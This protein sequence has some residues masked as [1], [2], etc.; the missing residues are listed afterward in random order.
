MREGIATLSYAVRIRVV[1]KYLGH[2]GIMMAI[3]TLAP[4]I[5]SLIFGEYVLSVRYALVVIALIALAAPSLRLRV[6]VGLQANEALAVTALVFVLTPLVMTYP[7]KGADL[8]VVDALFEAISAITTTGLS[9]LPSV[10]ALPKTSLFARAWMQWYGGLGIVVL[11]VALLMGHHTAARRLTEPVVGENMLTTARTYARRML[12]VYAALTVAGLIVLWLVIG[13]GFIALLHLLTAVS[14]GGFSPFD[15]SLAGLAQWPARFVLIA[16]A[17]CGAVPMVLYYRAYH[18]GWRNL[19]QDTELRAL[20]F[21]GLLTCTLLGFFMQNSL[22]LPLDEITAH[23]ILLGLS[24]QTG[25]GFSSLNV[26]ELDNA[27][28]LVLIVSMSIGGGVGSTTGGIKLLRLLILLRLLQL[29]I[30][31]TAA[32]SHAVI[33]PRLGGRILED[34]D[35]QRAMLLIILFMTVIVI[36]WLAFLIAGYAPLDALFEV[37]SATGTVGLSTGIAGPDLP[38][39]LKLVLCLDMLLGRLEIVALLVLIYPRTWF[40]KRSESL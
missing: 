23:A 37:V 7:L 33:K 34:D 25:T 3:L 15:N 22:V 16:F 21:A 6:P 26:V 29:A 20:L 2:L 31:R 39:A 9:T 14:T 28:K 32:P 18:H 12:G 1:I 38:P 30:Q 40:G 35:F 10:E 24:A 4:L 19:I 27:S 17:V 11:S 36:S 13:D 5:A 8:P